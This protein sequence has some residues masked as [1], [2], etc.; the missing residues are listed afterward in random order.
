M[1]TFINKKFP[2]DIPQIAH[3]SAQIHA[4]QY[5]LIRD[6]G[7]VIDDEFWDD[8][9]QPGWT[10]QLKLWPLAAM[11]ND[12]PKPRETQSQPPVLADTAIENDAINPSP[13]DNNE[14]EIFTQGPPVS[15]PQPSPTDDYY[16]IVDEFQSHVPRSKTRQEQPNKEELVT[17]PV[18][19]IFKGD[20]Q[21]VNIHVNSTHYPP[22]Q[23]NDNEE[24]ESEDEVCIVGE[25]SPEEEEQPHPLS[26]SP[27]QT[28]ADG[29]QDE[30]QNDDL[31]ETRDEP[32]QKTRATEEPPAT[33]TARKSKP[34]SKQRTTSK[35]Q[36][37]G[38]FGWI[39]RSAAGPSRSGHKKRGSATKTK[40]KS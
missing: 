8:I 27:A 24:S 29:A 17:C 19:M 13:Q 10:V 9:I 15:G 35:S 3:I 31:N 12:E 38:L 7:V 26:H 37:E 30:G 39:A 36:S 28:S 33:G 32:G 1:S 40:S 34:S 20:K 21:A 25:E 2:K 6:N 16:V 14:G 5:D 23:E 22:D 4:G 11:P 18:C